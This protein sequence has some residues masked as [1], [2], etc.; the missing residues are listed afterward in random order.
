[1]PKP[2]NEHTLKARIKALESQIA[3]LKNVAGALLKPESFET[4]ARSIFTTLK[5]LI[6][7]TAG[8][9]D[10]LSD[11]GV[12]NE[13]LLLDSGTLKCMVNPDLPMPIRG[14][15]ERVYKSREVVFEN[16]FLHS[17]YAGVLPL[18]HVEL[19][20]VMFVPL[21]VE[22][23]VVGLLGFAN[24]PGGFT[25]ED[26]QTAETFGGFAAIGLQNATL[27]EDRNT[28]EKSLLESENRFKKL[29]KM[30]REGV[31]FYEIIWDNV[32]NPLD[33]RYLDMNASFERAAGFQKNDVIGKLAT[34]VHKTD[35]PPYF[36]EF[37][38]VA[39]T[40]KPTTIEMYSSLLGRYFVVSVFSPGLNQFACIFNDTTYERM[41]KEYLS[42]TLNAVGEGVI[43]INSDGRI[44]RMNSMA[45]TMTDWKSAEGIGQNLDNV[46][47]VVEYDPKEK[48]DLNFHEISS[49][50]G[51]KGISD[52]RFLIS[53]TGRKY[54]IEERRV[55]VK[56]EDDIVCGCVDYF[57]EMNSILSG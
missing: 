16:K 54:I 6:G 5:D 1:M 43:E 15:R 50:G 34:E 23:T 12:E 33:Y 30:M 46:Y 39:Q 48:W 25:E 18:G 51:E 7:A 35:P 21:A 20:N 3:A 49:M 56:R 2:E 26:A 40:G 27:E 14:L 38:E 11:T 47:H 32:G 53:K 45:E 13:L 44:V 31:C 55:P 42:T 17:Q 9:V 22:N 4:T 10:L 19:I 24:K 28:F 36:K 52:Y 37:L 29:Y 8:F 57:L 41:N